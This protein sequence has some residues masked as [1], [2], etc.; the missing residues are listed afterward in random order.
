[1]I[2]EL[3][4]VQRKY[5]KNH[6]EGVSR[7]FALVVPFLEAP[8]REYVSTAYLICRVIDN[9]EDCHQPFDWKT[10]R[11]Q[12][13]SCLLAEPTQA[14]SILSS[15]GHEHWPGLDKNQASLMSEKDGQML[16]KI[17]AMIP[18]DSRSSIRHWAQ[19]MADGMDRLGDSHASPAWSRQKNIRLLCREKD[20]NEYC[21]IVAGTVGYMLTELVTQH[22]EFSDSVVKA[23]EPRAESCGRG[24][25][26]TNILKDFAEDLGRGVCYLP[27]E[28]LK[29]IHF[30]ALSLEGAPGHWKK[31]VIDD[32]MAELHSSI[33]FVLALPYQ[34][35]GFRMASL[36]SMLPA[37]QTIY[38][39]AQLQAQLFTPEH[40]VKISRQVMADCI[41]DAHRLQQNND[42]ILEYAY[43]IQQA[44]DSQ[45]E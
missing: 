13:I 22:Y 11:F 38:L 17:F 3:D 31:K 9:I 18:A 10:A 43:A 26:K 33:D 21:Y 35:E 44:I 12:E 42:G 14:F 39:A 4:P 1:L 6:M 37:M 27:E 7:S 15:W 40:H 25:Q 45:F 34:A 8:L 24:L 19:V 29:E 16:W 5:L 32:V 23:L 20:Y 2:F 36:L 28:W 41:R 30:S